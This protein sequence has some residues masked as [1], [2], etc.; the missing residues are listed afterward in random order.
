MSGGGKGWGRGRLRAGRWLLRSLATRLIIVLLVFLTVPLLVYEQFRGADLEKQALLLRSAQQQGQLIARA[1]EPLLAGVDSKSLMKLGERLQPYADADTSVR[2]LL[3]P[4]NAGGRTGEGFFYVASAPAVPTAAL[5]LE[6]ERL[7]EQGLLLRLAV[8][9][10]GDQPLAIPVPR[11]SG[12]IDLLTSITPIKTAMGCWAVVT[13]HTA[14]AYYNAGAGRPY[15]RTP[16]VQAASLIYVAMAALVLLLLLELWRNLRRFGELARDIVLHRSP[17]GSFAAQNSVPELAPVAEDFDRLVA[18]LHNSAANL[19]RAAEDNAHAFKTPIAVIRQSL[20]P[21]KRL[22]PPEDARGRRA[23]DMIEGSVERLDG[24]VSFARRMDETQADLLEPPRQRVDLSALLDRVLQGYRG[25]LEERA[26]DLAGRIEA[27]VVVRAGE[28]LLET[29]IENVVDNAI[30]FSPSGS[31]LR[32]TLRRDQG[33]ALLSVDDE[34]PGVDQA[35]LDKIFE[36]YFSQRQP[37][38]GPAAPAAG[39]DDGMPHYGIGL[40][41]VRRN[42]EAVGG[43]VEAVNRPAGGLS[44]RIHLPA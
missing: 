40:W 31:V 36:R 24:L 5:D 12:G 43:R 25:L 35:S 9:C 39:G 19:R 3:R 11:E 8:S 38:L 15:W 37:A 32:V 18:T 34:G 27:G 13:S 21:L 4:G 26:V 7:M 22:I 42:V 6:R 14:A 30:S 20:E 28:D 2:L 29:I 23:L 17:S 44:M 16:E 33:E 41:I 1:L 10:A